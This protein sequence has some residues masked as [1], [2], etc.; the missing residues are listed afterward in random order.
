MKLFA[1]FDQV[2]VLVGNRLSFVSWCPGIDVV[3]STFVASYYVH[4]LDC[5]RAGEVAQSIGVF[6]W[7]NH[8]VVFDVFHVPV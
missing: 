6:F 2:G 5:F 8:E 1:W 3:A 4:V 7:D